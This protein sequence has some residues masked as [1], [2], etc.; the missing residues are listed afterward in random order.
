MTTTRTPVERVTYGNLRVPRRPGVLGLGLAA[1]LGSGVAAVGVVVVLMYF[2]IL[3]ALVVGAVAAVMLAPLAVRGPDGRTGYTRM[4]G[5]LVH[6]RAAHTGRTVY[7]AG[8]SGQTPDGR[9]RLPG[10]LAATEL[11]ECVDAYGD[12][13]GMLV[14]P[15]VGHVSV[16]MQT[17]AT[18]DDLVDQH[19]TDSA[20]AHWGGWLARLG[21]EPDVVAA[22]V[23]VE[24]APDPGTKLLRMMARHTQP[25][26]PDFAR[27]TLEE[28]GRSYP[29]ASSSIT[30]RV[31]LTFTTRPRPGEDKRSPDEMAADVARRL[32]GF[33]HGL[34]TTGAGTTVRMMT[35][36]D[37]TDAVRVAYDPSVAQLVE[38]QRAEGGTGLVW[39]EAGPGFAHDRTEVYDHDGAHSI[40]WQMREAPP[41]VFYDNSLKALLAPHPDIDRKRVTLI[42]RPESAESARRIVER[43]VRDART[44]ATSRARP[45]AFDT[46]ML[47][48]ASKAAE[49]QAE[50]AGLVRFGIIVTAT[51]IDP[52]QLRRAA[53]TITTLAS[54][55]KLRLRLARYNQAATFA[56]GLP[57]G[58]VLP[59]H[60][61]LPDWARDAL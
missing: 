54:S 36:A 53:S 14:T 5:R 15:S 27:A 38:E 59:A 28:I 39:S 57:L 45:Q 9:T 17:E 58:L 26:A 6:R 35:G 29:D 31:A 48:A 49:E 60:L 19:V 3:E 11:V 21:Q 46:A 43:D 55:T 1:S 32:P 51:V 47:R 24:T 33:R 44:Q 61:A 10:L 23:T 42:Y 37:L 40:C 25:E 13:F 12:A 2:G 50:G 22:A 16:V 18:G 20:V 30:T 7:L 41:G 52:D 56:A 4:A 8:P 34:R